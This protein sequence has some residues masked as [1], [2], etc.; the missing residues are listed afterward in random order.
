M[1]D[2]FERKIRSAAIAGWW[3]VVFASVLLTASWIAYLVVLR[4]EPQWLL[5][6]WGGNL[7]LADVQYIWLWAI[8]V[9]KL[10]IWMM[11]CASLWA[12]LWAWRLRHVGAH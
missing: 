8:V 2:D 9:F 12:T 7:S 5:S 4:T 6:M 1:N 11:A 10:G 3:V